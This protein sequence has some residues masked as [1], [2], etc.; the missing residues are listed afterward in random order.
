MAESLAEGRKVAKSSES[1]PRLGFTNGHEKVV[2]DSK[3]EKK[4]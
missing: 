1:N 4:K 3:E 2:L